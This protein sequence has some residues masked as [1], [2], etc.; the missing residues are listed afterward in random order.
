ML[1]RHRDVEAWGDA[2]FARAQQKAKPV[3]P[4]MVRLTLRHGSPLVSYDPVNLDNLLAFAVVQEATQGL[5]VGNPPE[6]FVGWRIRLPLGRAWESEEGLP[7]WASTVFWPVPSDGTSAVGDVLYWHKRMPKGIWS[8]GNK[9]KLSLNGSTGRWM[10]RRT[11]VPITVCDTW[12]ARCVGDAAEVERL[13]GTC[14]SF[15]G[16]KR[17][18]GLGEVARWEVQPLPWPVAGDDGLSGILVQAG[19]LQRPI[20]V[21]VAGY[22]G[23]SLEESPTRIGWTPPQWNPK[24][25]SPGWH[26]GTRVAP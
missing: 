13:L 14:V 21:E 10:E 5:G 24:L 17:A 18:V 3:E 15:V 4:L 9:G 6:G 8:A 20:P 11:P 7:L 25:F 16:K 26:A 2:W 12:E 22:L 23:L 19:V 1:A